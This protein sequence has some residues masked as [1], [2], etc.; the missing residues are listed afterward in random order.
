MVGIEIPNEDRETVRLREILSTQAYERAES[1]K[2]Q[3]AAF[4][5][6][7]NIV[8][9]QAIAPVAG[10]AAMWV[11]GGH[12]AH[13]EH[14]RPHPADALV[15]RGWRHHHHCFV[16][17]FHRLQ[18]RQGVHHHALARNQFVLLRLDRTSPRA[19]ASTGHQ[20]KTAR[21]GCMRV[22]AGRAVFFR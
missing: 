7:T 18:R 22:G 16:K 10:G 12:I 17:S 2:M 21:G 20:G 8:A 13:G 3:V 4:E 19:R 11:A 1:G 15:G 9:E 14:V 5:V 6:R